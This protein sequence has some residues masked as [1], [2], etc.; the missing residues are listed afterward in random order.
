MSK[1]G[2][3]DGIRMSESEYYNQ[4]RNQFWIR[5]IVSMG[6]TH[7]THPY[8][9]GFPARMDCSGGG[10][11]LKRELQ[12]PVRPHSDEPQKR[13]ELVLTA[14]SRWTPEEGWTG[15]DS[16][17]QMN[18]RRGMNWSR[19]QALDEPQ[20]RDE[21]V[22]SAGSRCTQEMDEL[23]LAAGTAASMIIQGFRATHT[24]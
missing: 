24:L 7:Q 3:S 5:I 11:A 12:P 19:Q 8:R 2:G 1:L 20:T 23:V 18:P 10:Q 6:M 21:L 15:P 13:D 16:R 4:N 22:P 9:D 14:G 17:L